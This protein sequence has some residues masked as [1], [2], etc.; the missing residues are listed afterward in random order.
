MPYLFIP[1]FSVGFQR[2]KSQLGTLMALQKIFFYH[3]VGRSLLKACAY[4]C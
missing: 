4:E 3:F 1:T 2:G